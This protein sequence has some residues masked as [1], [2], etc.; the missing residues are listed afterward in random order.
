MLDAIGRI[1]IIVPKLDEHVLWRRAVS[2]YEA[3]W[4]SR[5]RDKRVEYI[6]ANSDSEA[7]RERITVNYLR[8]ELTSYE[9]QLASVYGSVGANDARI[10]IRRR[11]LDAIAEAYLGLRDECE[12]Q[13]EPDR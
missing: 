5:G 7:F 6:A 12:M 13:H 2:H 3:L 8:H 10:A 1:E 11:I 9:R 4:A